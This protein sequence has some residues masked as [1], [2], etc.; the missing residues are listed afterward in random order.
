M[1]T[2][3]LFRRQ[4]TANAAAKAPEGRRLY[5]VGDIHG[6]LDLLEG[7]LAQIVRDDAERDGPAGELIFL[8]DLID[9]GPDSA[10]V[11]DRLMALRAE[12]SNVRF[13]LGN[14]EEVF[15]NALS[16]DAK[17]LRLFSRIGGEETILSYGVSPQAYAEAD[18]EELHRLL[19]EAVPATHQ[20]FLESFENMI[21]AE[22]YVF[23]HAGIRPGVALADQRPADL[24]WIRDEF[25]RARAPLEKRVVHGHTI[26][27][28][29]VEL[30][31]RIGLDTGAYR[32]GILTAMGFEGEK[33]WIL[34]EQ[35]RRVAVA[36]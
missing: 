15:L 14:H 20:K 6:R 9:R 21:V 36:A 7:L 5:A 28:D 35:G 8:G 32:S 4:K 17:A 34:Q 26:S 16:G 31:H 12:R 25:L 30:P 2:K 11:V 23:V 33:R 10:R 19:V 1:L 22:D 29:V 27:E 3:L 18:Y 13:L 24:R